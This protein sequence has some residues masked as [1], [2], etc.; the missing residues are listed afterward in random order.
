MCWNVWSLT[1]SHSE[2]LTSSSSITLW[3][4][5]ICVRA[6]FPLNLCKRVCVHHVYSKFFWVLSKTPDESD[7]PGCF[8]LSSCL[9]SFLSGGE[10]HFCAF[11]NLI[12]S[13]SL[14]AFL[15]IRRQNLVASELSFLLKVQHG[16]I[17]AWN[18]HEINKDYPEFLC[19]WY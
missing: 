5:Y 18:N 16:R 3:L 13:S 4:M 14:I 15:V 7:P 8:T 1:L 2:S 11:A 10:S 17:L 12:V 9:H 6:S 19:C